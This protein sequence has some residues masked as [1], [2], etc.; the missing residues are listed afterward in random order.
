MSGFGRKQTSQFV[1][2]MVSARPLWGKAGI[3]SLAEKVQALFAYIRQIL[4]PLRTNRT[5]DSEKNRPYSCS[6]IELPHK[7][8][9]LGP[10]R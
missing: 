3:S 10:N 5:A 1:D 4:P 6:L 2:S 9:K 8:G 7:V